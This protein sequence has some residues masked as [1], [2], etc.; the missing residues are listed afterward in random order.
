M[1]QLISFYR[2][3][4]EGVKIF[5]SATT[6]AMHSGKVTYFEFLHDDEDYRLNISWGDTTDV[7]RNLVSSSTAVKKW[8]LWSSGHIRLKKNAYIIFMHLNWDSRFFV[9]F[10]LFNGIKRATREKENQMVCFLAV[11]RDEKAT[12]ERNGAA[13]KR[14]WEHVRSK[15]IPFKRSCNPDKTLNCCPSSPEL[16]YHV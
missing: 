3:C 14:K 5:K 12:W 10:F 13:R 16:N 9:L 4:L 2:Q 1:N 11:G 8:N 6:R 7:G 15:H